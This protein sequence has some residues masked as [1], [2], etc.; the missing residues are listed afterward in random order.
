MLKKTLI[1]FVILNLNVFGLFCNPNESEIILS[2]PDQIKLHIPKGS[3]ISECF[4][5]DEGPSIVVSSEDETTILDLDDEPPLGSSETFKT[6]LTEH[7]YNTPIAIAVTRDGRG[8]SRVWDNP[9]ILNQHIYGKKS[10]STAPES[11]LFRSKKDPFRN[12]CIGPIHYLTLNVNPDGTVSQKYLGTDRELFQIPEDPQTRPFLALTLTNLS[13]PDFADPG[14][15]KQIATHYGEGR[16]TTQDLEAK[17]IYKNLAS[18]PKQETQIG[19]Q[20]LRPS[21]SIQ[22]YVDSLS[23]LFTRV[24]LDENRTE[25]PQKITIIP[26]NLEKI[27]FYIQKQN[28]KGLPA[29]IALVERKSGKLEMHRA[30]TLNRQLFL[31]K[32][33]G[34]VALGAYCLDPTIIDIKYF[35]VQY[36]KSEHILKYLCSV[37]DLC[38]FGC[39]PDPYY[40]QAITCPQ[41]AENTELLV[42]HAIALFKN[43]KLKEEDKEKVFIL[44]KIAAE[45]G[46]NILA[47]NN[48]AY[49]YSIGFGVEQNLEIASKIYKEIELD[50]NCLPRMLINKRLNEIATDAYQLLGK[51]QPIEAA[52]KMVAVAYGE[53]RSKFLRKLIKL[54]ETYLANSYKELNAKKFAEYIE[55]VL[56]LDPSNN[57]KQISDFAK[58]IVGQKSIL[59]IITLANYFAKKDFILGLKYYAIAYETSQ[60]PFALKIFKQEMRK[61]LPSIDESKLEKFK[62]LADKNNPTLQA[63]LAYILL[64]KEKHNESVQYA[65]MAVHAENPMALCIAGR[66]YYYNIATEENK[67]RGME[68]IQ[69]AADKGY[70]PALRLLA[71]I[72]TKNNDPVRADQLRKEANEFELK[73][74]EQFF[75]HTTEVL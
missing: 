32:L 35:T 49:C 60:N 55:A 13:E 48:L 6:L 38:I 64:L 57:N 24:I 12:I 16:G 14:S 58:K 1:L 52:K 66:A 65:E 74:R 70:P 53:L 33:L 23:A 21:R 69:K 25:H 4:I 10:T 5:P 43:P 61:Q 7:P 11:M 44:F 46:N 30:D 29:T 67:P 27:R 50:P 28:S 3:K 45:N 40:L 39:H 47:K 8:K 54:A 34:K 63:Y 37:D 31:E 68:Y 72:Y 26:D 51:N 73:N 19:E 42:K 17:R 22:Q 9:R 59:G 20:A 71:T 41:V 36:E 62:K 15:L 75:T 2:C 18:R 56:T